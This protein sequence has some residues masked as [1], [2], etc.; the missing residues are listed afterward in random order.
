MYFSK[1]NKKIVKGVLPNSYNIA[2]V[3]VHSGH[4]LRPTMTISGE[5]NISASIHY[6]NNHP[7]VVLG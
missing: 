7:I 3:L 2:M 6:M 5:N 4:L 1:K